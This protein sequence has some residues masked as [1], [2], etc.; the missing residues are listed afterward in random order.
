METDNDLVSNGVFRALREASPHLP[1]I[2]WSNP[3]G[4]W[5]VQP[6]NISLQFLG[7]A[8]VWL[9]DLFSTHWEQEDYSTSEYLQKLKTCSQCLSWRGKAVPCRVESGSGV[10]PLDLN[11][12]NNIHYPYGLKQVLISL[13]LNFLSY[14]LR[15]IKTL[16]SSRRLNV[17]FKCLLLC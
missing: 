11:L 13:S 6:E 8:F 17:C 5:Q 3:L 9:Y 15:V 12:Y 16:P 14:K 2:D 7:V 1:C 10:R 4:G